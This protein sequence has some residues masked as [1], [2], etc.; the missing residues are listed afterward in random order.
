MNLFE[1][2]S[3]IVK[4]NEPLAPY[5]WFKLGGPARYFIEPR[6]QDELVEI[7]RRCHD[8]NIQIY[9]LGRGSNLLVGDNGVSGAVVRLSHPSFAKV[10]I[11]DTVVRAGAGASLSGLIRQCARHGLSGAECLA[12]IP[13]TVGGAIRINAGGRFGDIGNITQSVK[14]MDSSSY[15]FERKR[16]DIYFGYRMT[17]I[18]ARFILEAEFL[19]TPDE[20]ENIARL[21]KEVWML[22]KSSQ[23]M[24]SRNA[25]CVF[26]NPRAMSAGAL[27]DKAGL[28]GAQ[29]GGARVSERHANFI[30]AEDNATA[31][32]VLALIDKI[33]DAVQARFDVEIELEID[34]W[35]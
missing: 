34:I 8:N 18:M 5:T 27:I 23:P 14:L 30:M 13:G 4:E 29:I 12:G 31:S 10:T 21:L 20:P 6:D 19:L 25:G 3:E 26:K 17:N 11:D 35:Q 22:K 33:K 9:V 1:D 28:K 15:R 24:N 16:D 7:T 2:L 32:D